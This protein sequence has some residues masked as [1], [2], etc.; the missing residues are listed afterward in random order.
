LFLVLL[1]VVLTVVLVLEVAGSAYETGLGPDAGSA[2]QPDAPAT[3]PG[4]A[5]DLPGTSSADVSRPVPRQIS[6]D[7]GLPV[8][9]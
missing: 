7:G 3:D 6:G 9:R 1:I 5:P 4:P 8:A 2:I